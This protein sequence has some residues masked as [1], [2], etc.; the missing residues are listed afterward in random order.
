MVADDRVVYER[1]RASPSPTRTDS[2]AKGAGGS[3]V[4]LSREGHEVGEGTCCFCWRMFDG[5]FLHNFFWTNHFTDRKVES[6]K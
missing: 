6:M 3:L 4:E 2:R 5:K 1:S